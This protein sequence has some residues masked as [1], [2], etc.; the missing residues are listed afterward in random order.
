MLILYGKARDPMYLLFQY[1]NIVLSKVLFSL[2]IVLYG[3]IA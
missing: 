1:N 2:C 3:G